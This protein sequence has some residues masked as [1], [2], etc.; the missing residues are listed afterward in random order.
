MVD[1][2]K[3]SIHYDMHSENKKA[4]RKKQNQKITDKSETGFNF[5]TNRHK[6][7]FYPFLCWKIR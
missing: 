2:Q 5:S 6:R 3:N 1:S 7:A 4:Q